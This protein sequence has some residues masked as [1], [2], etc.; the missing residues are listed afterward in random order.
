V[1]DQFPPAVINRLPPG[2]LSQLGIK[3][4]GRNPE[5][6]SGIVSACV[7][8]WPLYLLP[9]E[10]TKFETVAPSAAGN[11]GFGTVIGAVPAD[12]IWWVTSYSVYSDAL[13]AGQAL[14]MTCGCVD[15]G[16]VLILGETSYLGGPGDRVSCV[17]NKSP[18]LI[19]S[20]QSSISVLVNFMTAGPINLNGTIT[21]SPLKI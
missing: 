16:S 18:F 15:R 1:P 8:L 21:Y 12:E 19:S 2:L 3:S 9:T 20:G 17:M 6:L 13:T 14:R 10:I 11:A 7:E 5:L 4:G